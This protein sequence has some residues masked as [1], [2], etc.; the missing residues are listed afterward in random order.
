MPPTFP[1]RKLCRPL[2]IAHGPE[3]HYLDSRP[4][5]EEP[6]RSGRSLCR[7]AALRLN[8]SLIPLIRDQQHYFPIN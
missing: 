4:I 3:R 6:T 8:L 7:E 1:L 5:L 2:F